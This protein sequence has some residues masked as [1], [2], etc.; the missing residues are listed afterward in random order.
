MRRK[1]LIMTMMIIIIIIIT[2]IIIVHS[3]QVLL[4]L[5]FLQRNP[6]LPSPRGPLRS[7]KVSSKSQRISIQT[8]QCTLPYIP[9]TKT[10]TLSPLPDPK[11]KDILECIYF[12]WGSPFSLKNSI[13]FWS[14]GMLRP[15]PKTPCPV[16]AEN[17]KFV[18]PGD[19]TISDDTLDGA[20]IRRFHQLIMVSLSHYLPACWVVVWD[21]WTI[22]QY[23]SS[24]MDNG[25]WMVGDGGGGLVVFEELNSKAKPMHWCWSYEMYVN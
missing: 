23:V 5:P 25:C 24:V 2:S 3:R 17:Y 10:R 16:E 11:R 13:P 4:D 20:E 8:D 18:P 6:K 15:P 12:S 21:S 1:R 19:G 22:R 14:T 9:P 7:S